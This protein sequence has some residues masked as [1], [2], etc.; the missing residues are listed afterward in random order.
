V[1]SGGALFANAGAVIT[2][3][4]GATFDIRSA[5]NM[6]TN[7][8]AWSFVNQGTVIKSSVG[9]V[10]YMAPAFTNAGLLSVVTGTL[11]LAGGGVS[12]GQIAVEA[13]ATVEMRTNAYTLAAGSSVQGAGRMLFGAN[14][15]VES[16]Y[17]VTG[18]TEVSGGTAVTFAPTAT[19]T[20]LGES[21]VVAVGDLV[22][23]SGE[24]VTLPNLT[25]NSGF[26]SGSDAI[27]VTGGFTWNSGT[28][29]GG[30]PFV[31]TGQMN[32]ATNGTKVLRERRLENRGNLVWNGGAFFV[33]NGA[34]IRNLPG[35]T[36]DIRTDAQFTY[37]GTIPPQVLNEGAL[38]KSAGAL[39]QTVYG[40]ITNTG[41]IQVMTGTLFLR[42][43]F[44]QTAGAT[45][46]EGGNLRSAAAL[47]V[48]GGVL[49]GRGLISGDLT[50]GATV[51]VEPLGAA[52]QVSGRYTQLPTG[53]LVIGLQSADPAAGFDRLQ[54]G[55]QAVL[56]GTLTIER[57]T[58]YTPVNGES[59][60]VVTFASRSGQF[61]AI[62]GLDLG[63]GAALTPVY[64]AA[65]LTLQAP[66]GQGV[67]GSLMT[68]TDGA[69]MRYG[70][71]CQAQ[72]TAATPV[73][74]MA[75]EGESLAPVAQLY[76]L[77]VNGVAFPCVEA[78]QVR[79]AAAEQIVYGPLLIGGVQV[80]RQVYVPA[81]GNFVRTI[82]ALSNPTDAAQTVAVTVSGRLANGAALRLLRALFKPRDFPQV[83][84]LAVQRDVAV[85]VGIPAH[86]DLAEAEIGFHLVIP[87]RQH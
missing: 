69:G 80:T 2:N 82:E 29:R 3:L 22:L 17:A 27:T 25:L 60:P 53:N 64:N 61:T 54:I 75:A 21:V 70:V 23:N 65:N 44:V 32:L 58:G 79:A 18:I 74:G 72:V 55:G 52:L 12:T 9:G 20:T 28:L 48:Q 35:A 26:I 50:N 85:A 78:A 7:P 33:A 62:S 16:Q 57:P 84:R 81:T 11:Q 86:A 46:L 8:T 71:D 5:A 45:T 76:A 24:A 59:F 63:A 40:V 51:D 68:L 19:L 39:E 77:T 10:S 56:S 38:L 67:N 83:D 4:P 13:G 30:S 47:Q 49:R 15:L 31:L 6:N 36:F 66:T 87:E 34:L 73:L 42:N 41:T 14:A 1:W 43:S 37:D